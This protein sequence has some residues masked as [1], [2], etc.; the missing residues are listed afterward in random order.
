MDE[1]LQKLIDLMPAYRRGEL[2]PRKAHEISELLESD[3]EFAREAD[4]EM[5]LVETL[6]NLDEIPLPRG[7]VTRSVKT[8][9]SPDAKTSWFSL[10]TLLIALGVGVIC[11][12][13]AQFITSKFTLP[14][15][16]ELLINFANFASGNA[17]GVV[18]AIYIVAIVMLGIGAWLAIRTIRS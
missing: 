15:V 16:G 1:R 5:V 14:A 7:L 6:S 11:A 10:E 18:V 3:E 12:A 2:S 4:R 17:F 9:V 13:I 8:A